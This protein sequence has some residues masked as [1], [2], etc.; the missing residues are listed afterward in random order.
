[1]A[2][3]SRIVTT[4]LKDG[5]KEVA[6]LDPHSGRVVARY[7]TGKSV[8]DK[9]VRSIKETLERKRHQVDVIEK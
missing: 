1:M 9:D 3:K 2:L 7:E 5:K 4:D 6:V 8:A